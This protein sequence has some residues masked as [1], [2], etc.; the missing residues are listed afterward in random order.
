MDF[1]Y[2]IKIIY[3]ILPAAFA[4]MAPV[5]VKK[6]PMLSQP[7]DF[8]A[9]M[10]NERI[11]G[12]NKTWRGLAFG[13]AFAVLISLLQGYLYQFPI[14]KS[15]SFADYSQVNL[16]MLG[17]LFGLGAMTGDIVKSFVKRR[18][19]I[20]PGKSMLV[21]D[22]IDWIIGALLFVSLIINLGWRMI[23]ASII[24][25]FF[26]HLLVKCIGYFLRIEDKPL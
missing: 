21:F 24:L 23:I 8:N 15:V 14:I 20:P 5:L 3:F 4:N 17:F 10:G 11:L 1:I 22:Q 18:L 13:I 7:I 6:L 12:K 16:L 19:G 25:F 9:S 26:L 2:L